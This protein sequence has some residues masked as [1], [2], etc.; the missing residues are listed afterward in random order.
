M[1]SEY[2]F[3]IDLQNSVSLFGET[4]EKLKRWRWNPPMLRCTLCW[5]HW[6]ATQL[7]IWSNG[8]CLQIAFCQWFWKRKLIR[9]LF[10]SAFPVC[11]YCLWNL[12][13]KCH[14]GFR[15]FIVGVENSKFKTISNINW[16]CGLW[17]VGLNMIICFAFGLSTN[18]NV[19]TFSWIGCIIM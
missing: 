13:Q 7:T 14:P 2:Y 8:W 9:F 17:A 3:S 19:N 10:C 1:V 15:D 18:Q 11:R 6:I 4:K 12:T 5:T 16:S